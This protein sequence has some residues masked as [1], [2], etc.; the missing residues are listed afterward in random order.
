M[1]DL[2]PTGSD[3]DALRP[4]APVLAL[5]T[6]EPPVRREDHPARSWGCAFV[7][8]ALRPCNVEAVGIGK[9]WKDIN[10]GLGRERVGSTLRHPRFH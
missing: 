5:D 2:V 9:Y 1:N 3:I 7:R 4:A 6:A 10:R 8:F